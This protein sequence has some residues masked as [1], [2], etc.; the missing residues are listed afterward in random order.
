LLK[1]KQKKQ[2]F[3]RWKAFK[4]IRKIKK[5]LKANKPNQSQKQQ[6]AG[7]SIMWWGVGIF[8]L[9]AILTV[10]WIA[11]TGMILGALIFLVGLITRIDEIGW[12]ATTVWIGFFTLLSI[13]LVDS[14]VA[15]LLLL[16]G[17]LS[18]ILL[19]FIM[20]VYYN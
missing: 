6:D 10:P 4:K 3:K 11:I 19:G 15:M 1:K 2:R 16:I 13:L 14:F 18:L 7:R 9:S 8:L 12:G 17:G 20:I 5:Q